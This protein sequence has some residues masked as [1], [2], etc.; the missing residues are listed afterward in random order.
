MLIG[1]KLLNLHLA[2]T[3]FRTV[4]QKID[5]LE[6]SDGFTSLEEEFA[7]RQ[8]HMD[9][10][11]ELEQLKGSI[12]TEILSLYDELA[13][14]FERPVVEVKNK[15]CLGC[16][17]PL[18]MVNLSAWRSAKGVVQCDQCDRILC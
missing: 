4:E 10:Q 3:D 18:S 8:Q 12:P 13:E 16:F 6:S 7:I 1:R 17:M 14:R 5:Q 15:S 11:F 2:I 9:L